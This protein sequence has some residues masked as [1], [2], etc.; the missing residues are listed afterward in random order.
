MLTEEEARERSEKEQNA[1]CRDFGATPHIVDAVH[2]DDRSE[3]EE[4]AKQRQ[5]DATG[6]REKAPDAG[7]SRK[8]CSS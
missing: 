8:K 6:V 3:H 7:E 1:Y 5:Y 4:D 2:P